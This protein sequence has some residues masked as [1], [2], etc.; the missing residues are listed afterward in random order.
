[1]Q[2]RVT[3]EDSSISV[4]H[5]HANKLRKF[6]PR[7]ANIGVIFEEDEEFGDISYYPSMIHNL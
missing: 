2:N 3:L 1:M 7:V 5:M 6:I 4:R